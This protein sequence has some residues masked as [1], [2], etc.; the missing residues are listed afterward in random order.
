MKQPVIHGSA[1][2][3]GVT[4]WTGFGGHMDS[5]S[6]TAAA[7]T[8]W[9]TAGTISKIKITLKVAPGL[10]NS[11]TCVPYVNGIASAVSITIS[12]TDP[13]GEDLVN[14]ITVAPGDK[15]RMLWTATGTPAG[16]AA[17]YVGFEF[18]ST[19]PKESNYSQQ[20]T[21]CITR[22]TGVFWPVLSS[23]IWT[24][25][26]GNVMANVVPTTGDLKALYYHLDGAP[27]AG[28]AYHFHVWLNGVKQ[29][30]AGGTV[31]TGVT[32]ADGATDNFGTFT[33]ALVATDQVYIEVTTT[34]AVAGRACGVGARFLAAVDGESIAGGWSQLDQ[35]NPLFFRFHGSGGGLIAEANQ[36]APGVATTFGLGRL[37]VYAY[38]QPGSGKSHTFTVRQGG[39]TSLGDVVEDLTNAGQDLVDSIQIGNA[40][41]FSMKVSPAGTPTA[42]FGTWSAVQTDLNLP[43]VDAGPDQSIQL[44][45]GATTLAGSV[46]NVGSPFS[47]LWTVDSGPHS[48]ADDGVVFSDP[49]SLTPTVSVVYPGT[50]VLRL[51]LFYGAGSPQT[52]IFDTMTLVVAQQLNPCTGGGTFAIEDDPA[53]G[54]PLEAAVTPLTWVTFHFDSGDLPVSVLDLPN[55]AG[56]HGGHAEARVV[57]ITRPRRAV[58]DQFGG[59][60]TQDVSV[61]VIDTDRRFR[62][63]KDAETLEGRTFDVWAAD[64]TVRRA[65]GQAKR[66]GHYVITSVLPLGDMTFQV[67]GSDFVGSVLSRFYAEKQLHDRLLNRT[68]FPQLPLALD[69]KR[70]P[71]YYGWI[72]DDSL[73][74]LAIAALDLDHTAGYGGVLDGGIYPLFG[75]GTVGVTGPASLTLGE[76]AG[77][78][79][80]AGDVAYVFATAVV[81]GVES[82]PFPVSNADG[83]DFSF[84]GS[85]K[86]LTLACAAVTGATAYRWYVQINAPWGHT[87]TPRDAGVMRETAGNSTELTDAGNENIGPWP[88]PDTNW[89]G[90]ST[91]GQMTFVVFARYPHGLTPRQAI[92]GTAD[93]GPWA[94]RPVRIGWVAPTPLPTEYWVI[95]VIGTTLVNKWIVANTETYLDLTPGSTPDEIINGTFVQEGAIPLR[96]VGRETVNGVERHAFLASLGV[97]RINAVHGSDLGTPATRIQL[98]DSVYGSTL[99]VPDKAGWMFATLYRAFTDED[100]DEQWFTMVYGAVGDPVVEAAVDGTVPLTANT[101]GF[102]QDSRGVDDN[103]DPS[104]T[105]DALSD[106][107]LHFFENF[108]DP[109]DGE[110][111]K[112]GPWKSQHVRNGVALRRGSSFAAAKAYA[113]TLL[114]GGFPGA[115]GFCVDLEP[116]TLDT[117]LRAAA[118]NHDWRWNQTEHGQLEPLMVDPAAASVATFSDGTAGAVAANIPAHEPPQF[119]PSA[120]RRVNRILWV[121]KKNYVEPV[122]KPTP[123]Q[124]DLLPRTLTDRID[125]YSGTLKRDDDDSQLAFGGGGGRRD[126]K[127]LDVQF[128]MHRTGG[129]PSLIVDRFLG[130]WGFPLDGWRFPASLLGADVKNGRVVLWTHHA[131]SGAGGA[132]DRRLWLTASEPD[133]N[134]DPG[135][136]ASLDVWLEGEDIT[137]IAP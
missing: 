63:R 70:Q 66:L 91:A 14:T 33:L 95:S 30:G 88:P 37:R 77:G 116:I 28:T 17:A 12:G 120:A 82:D 15:L 96:Y 123:A 112:S 133:P 121:Y 41:S 67:N 11:W 86:K 124:D 109:Q 89:S 9:A 72:G 2:V 118:I 61:V 99:W 119:L 6:G 36:L 122:T 29:D 93:W 23:G 62:T 117:F 101:C 126:I 45:P 107:I 102:S 104:P 26:A 52:Q 137:R 135:N 34:G 78:V 84:S 40:D 5:A 113:E 110:I 56:Y 92:A 22:R 90:I 21:T 128:A 8:P 13:D 98:D 60:Q 1:G 106:Q 18:D 65:Q 58:S 47:V 7:D 55:A 25:Q 31:D 24:S 35:S 100:G 59:L 54:E 73:P 48:P 114:S 85:G 46:S 115:W 129:A 19:N 79:Y 105:I 127:P 43:T 20:P 71:G 50:Y 131:G 44:P 94:T 81:S 83:E 32:I 4:G 80:G 132:I 130:R 27:G 3:P 75:W 64:D 68:L 69:G 74:T 38:T 49:T 87:A 108:A 42:T 76:A 134:L 103:G 53:D 57:S 125:W 97:I 39:D 16:M 111:W 136:P 51:T 10:G